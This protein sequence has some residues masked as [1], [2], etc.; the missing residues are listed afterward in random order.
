[1]LL[2]GRS[3]SD[4]VSAVVKQDVMIDNVPLWV[5]LFYCLR[6]GARNEAVEIVSQVRPLSSCLWFICSATVPVG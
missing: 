1:M 4:F 5:Q 3:W 2:Q 6:C